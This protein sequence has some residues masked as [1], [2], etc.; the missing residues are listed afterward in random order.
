MVDSAGIDHW[1]CIPM[2]LLTFEPE[3]ITKLNISYS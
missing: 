3:I 2:P 1:M